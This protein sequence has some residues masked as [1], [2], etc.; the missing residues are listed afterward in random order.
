MH[1]REI[2][3]AFS[4]L[5]ASE[6]LV[7]EIMALK[8]EKKTVSRAWRIATRA[9]VCAAVVV[10]IVLTAVLWPRGEGPGNQ[11]DTPSTGTTAAPT[12]PT[13]PIAPTQTQGY[14]LVMMSNVLKLYSYSQENVSEEELQKYE[15]TDGISTY[16]PCWMEYTTAREIKMKFCFPKEYYA[17]AELTFQVVAPCGYYMGVKGGKVEIGNGEI[18]SWRPGDD[19]Q[20]M[21][22][23]YNPGAFYVYLLIYADDQPVGFGLLELSCLTPPGAPYTVTLRRF[24][25]ICYPLVDG[26]FQD[27]TEEYLWAQIEEC[28]QAMHEEYMEHLPEML[29]KINK[30]YEESRL[31]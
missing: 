17:G 26:Q 24:R 18:S 22:E 13:T 7:K 20:N 15:I 12:M 9:A 8:S 4:Q 19:L 16:T 5:H 3:E 1:K 25:T 11:L 27:V 30:A 21:K 29:E 6:E 10:A 2:K 31:N 14:E 23:R 28:E